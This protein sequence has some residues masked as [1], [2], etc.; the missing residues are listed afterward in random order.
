MQE[1]EPILSVKINNSIKESLND[2]DKLA[3]HHYLYGH[4]NQL[5][6]CNLD[7]IIVARQAVLA[8]LNHFK[9]NIEPNAGVVGHKSHHQ[10]VDWGIVPKLQWITGKLSE[11]FSFL[12]FFKSIMNNFPNEVNTFGTLFDG[13]VSSWFY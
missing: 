3:C 13:E 5:M 9:C 4:M 12:Q 8:M 10:N 6:M 7:S 11:G 2:E 1:R